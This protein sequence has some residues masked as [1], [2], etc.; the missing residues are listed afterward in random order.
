MQP[1]ER[2][3]MRQVRYVR[4]L[5][6]SCVGSMS[7]LVAYSK[8]KWNEADALPRRPDFKPL[9]YGG[10]APAA[11]AA[12]HMPIGSGPPSGAEDHGAASLAPPP[13]PSRGSRW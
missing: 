6:Q 4:E 11:I 2:M 3:N 8:N 13:P 7:L 5:L 12:A 9:N 1:T 10:L